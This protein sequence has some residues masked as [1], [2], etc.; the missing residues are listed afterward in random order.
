[1]KTETKK[2]TPATRDERRETRERTRMRIVDGT[3][4][5]KTRS[6]AHPRRRRRPGTL[7]DRLLHLSPSR[8][9]VTL[10][11]ATTLFFASAFAPP[12]ASR[13]PE[14]FLGTRAGPS[15]DLHRSSRGHDP[16]RVVIDHH[17][18]EPRLFQPRHRPS[19]DV[20]RALA[21]R[22]A[23]VMIQPTLRFQNPKQVSVKLAREELPANANVGGSCTM[24]SNSPSG[25]VGTTS[26]ALPYS[27]WISPLKSAALCGF[28]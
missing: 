16:V 26:A 22:V 2:K 25:S 7:F 13:F 5:R 8:A 27:C 3:N 23:D 10:P 17:T 19:R 28:I 18:P 11:S 20:P 9:S 1:M 4:V 24:R 21:R 15:R 6:R 14:G 12:P